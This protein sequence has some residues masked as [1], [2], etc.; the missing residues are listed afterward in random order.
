MTRPK[1]DANNKFKS[2][3]QE[4]VLTMATVIGVFVGGLVGFIIKNS[5][6]E[7]SK[8]EIMYISFPGE[9]FLR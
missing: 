4:N 6:G 1:Q 9:I 2:F 7:W 5:T 3:M 8:R